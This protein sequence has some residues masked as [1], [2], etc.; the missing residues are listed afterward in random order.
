MDKDTKENQPVQSSAFELDINEVI[1]RLAKYLLEG[2]VVAFVAFV[3][4][5]KEQL[6]LESIIYLGLV[7]AMTFSVLDL[8]SP[9]IGS[10]GRAAVGFG[11]GS[12][13]VGGMGGVKPSGFLGM[14]IKY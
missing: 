1:V 4:P 11:V 7:A 5:S 6:P 3:V 14:P 12:N 9:S 13:L 10:T 8:F 2:I